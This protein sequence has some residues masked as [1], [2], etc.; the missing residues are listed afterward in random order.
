MKLACLQKSL[1]RGLSTV[2]HAVAGSKSPMQVLSNVLL[3]AQGD[4]LQLAAT[5]LEII[6]TTRI[7]ARVE[8]EGAI[9]LPAKLLSDVVGGLP[10]DDVKLTLDARTQTVRL[11]CARFTSNI[12]GIDADEF[13]RIPTTG[14]QPPTI[15][16]PPD[17]LRSAIDQVVFA[18]AS[19]ESRPVLAGVLV[20]L[21]PNSATL[22]AADGFRLATRSITLPDGATRA[23]SDVQEFIVPGR[24]F[25]ELS[26]ILGEAEGDVALTVLPGGSQVFFHTATTD[27]LSRL[28]D[29]KF[30]DF[31]R[32]I[33]SSHA[34][35]IVLEAQEL[36][37]AVKLASFFAAQSQSI[38][39]LA[40]E[41]GTEDGPG[42]LVISANAAE[43]GDNTGELDGVV[44][45]EGGQLALNVKFLS[46]AL[47]ALKTAQVAI[48][49]QSA[50][51]PGVFR[52][53]GQD[54]YI[55]IIM[56]MALR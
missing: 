31:E 25:A 14:D 44:E 26:A 18:A 36:A 33:P 55:H 43:V 34:T 16:L 2:S 47:G 3:S 9:A 37:R 28:I 32:I 40:V 51:H 5:D 49:M 38:V 41:P 11:E 13:P 53:I 30:P 54:D 39:K 45:G 1:K 4:Q 46:E 22:A 52:P 10:N 50:Q 48:E 29:G 7:D 27:L 15:S 17:L 24:A 19:D 23:S 56:P 35:R 6:I 12:K 8:E 20:R 21:L 42:K